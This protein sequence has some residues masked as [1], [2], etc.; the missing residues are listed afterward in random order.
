MY[1]FHFFLILQILKRSCT[2]ILSV[3]PSSVCVNGEWILLLRSVP[4]GP[5]GLCRFRPSFYCLLTELMTSV[6]KGIGKMSQFP[7]S[8]E[9]ARLFGDKE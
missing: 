7:S 5:E 2:E 3:E 9:V 4:G 8:G 1:P 6:E